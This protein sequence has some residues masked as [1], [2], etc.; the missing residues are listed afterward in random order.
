MALEKTV[1]VSNGLSVPNAYIRIDSIGGYKGRL[2]VSVNSY[3]SKE[4]FNSD[5]AY[6]EQQ[7]H[8]FVPSV[9]EG[10]PNFIKQAYEY[11]KTLPEFSES[12]DV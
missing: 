3:V 1:T 8:H 4:A 5:Q 12:V 9:D 6:L 7:I 10:S 11:L 2:D